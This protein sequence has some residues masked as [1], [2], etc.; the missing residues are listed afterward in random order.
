MVGGF[1]KKI[2]NHIPRDKETI[3]KGGSQLKIII[4]KYD[5]NITNANKIK[6]KGKSAREQGEK[7]SIIHYVITSQEYME[8]IKSTEI[9][10]EKQ[11]GLYKVERQNKQIKKTYSGR[12]AI[13]INLDFISPK[14][15]SRKKKVITRK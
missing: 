13:R 6:G 8:T 12:N 2:G 15:V 9:H 5:L 10:Q 11:Y 4:E 1:N 3:S 7:R 14:E